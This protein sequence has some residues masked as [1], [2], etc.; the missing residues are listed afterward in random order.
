MRVLVIEDEQNLRDQLAQKLRES[1]Y[2]VDTADDGET[3]LYYAREYPIDVAIVDIGLPVMSGVDVIK[4][5]T[6]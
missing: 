4:D 1:G 2:V 3:G 6:Q 5:L